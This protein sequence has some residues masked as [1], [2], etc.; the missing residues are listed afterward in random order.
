MMRAGPVTPSR[1]PAG[2]LTAGTGHG[3]PRPG[4]R[5]RR[6]QAGTAAVSGTGS[7][8]CPIARHGDCG[9]T[10]QLLVLGPK[11][12]LV[13]VPQHL[14]R[15]PGPADRGGLGVDGL[16]RNALA[17]G[18]GRHCGGMYHLQVQL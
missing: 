10:T 2:P 11:W 8:T 14:P 9:G 18:L 15:T 12:L 3:R 16:A 13:V 5:R 17:G 4:A 7:G 6:A 1:L